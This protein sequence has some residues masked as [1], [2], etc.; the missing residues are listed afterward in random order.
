MIQISFKEELRVYLVLLV[1]L[2]L[3]SG[4]ISSWSKFVVS[5]GFNVALVVMPSGYFV[6]L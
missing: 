5:V 1:L 6:S 2:F 3:F 4:V